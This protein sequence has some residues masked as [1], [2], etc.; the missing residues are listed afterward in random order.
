MHVFIFGGLS[1]STL[2]YNATGPQ[3]GML[4][5]TIALALIAAVAQWQTTKNHKH[6]Q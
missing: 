4:F 2:R 3:Y 6:R 5:G 1:V